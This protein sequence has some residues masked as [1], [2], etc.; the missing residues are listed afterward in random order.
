M[1]ITRV[2]S[3]GGLAD[4]TSSITLA[5]NSNVTAG[6]LLVVAC[7]KYSPGNDA[8]DVDLISKSAG[9]ATLGTW[10]LD[11]QFSRLVSGSIYQITAIFSVPVTGSGSCTITIS[12]ALSGSYLAIGLIEYS[13]ADVT[14]SR[15]EDTATAGGSS[16]APS[17]GDGSSA[18]GAAFV[19][20][21]APDM[22]STASITED[23]AFYL[24]YENTDYS[25]E[26]AS[27]ISRIVTGSTTDAASWSLGASGAWAAA[28]TVYLAGGGSSA[29]PKIMLL[30]DHFSGG[31]H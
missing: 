1:S 14:A 12:G 3:R 7:S 8:F 10:T 24:V 6:N 15:V 16:T 31:I 29:V 27:F 28:L 23:G 17:S 21:L 20:S 11:A 2:Q 13:G 30:Q 9:T 18:G 22:G 25:S 5:Y 19:G 4:N 26:Q